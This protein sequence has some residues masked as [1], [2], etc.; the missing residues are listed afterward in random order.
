MFKLGKHVPYDIYMTAL[1]SVTVSTVSQWSWWRC[2]AGLL[3]WGMLF[4][5]N[6][7]DSLLYYFV[8]DDLAQLEQTLFIQSA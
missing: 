3:K 8:H 4:M 6:V 5:R 2:E 7:A 1:V